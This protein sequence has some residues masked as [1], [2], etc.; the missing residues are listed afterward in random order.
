MEQIIR[1]STHKR[2]NI[3]DLVFVSHSDLWDHVILSSS[4][5]D[6]NPIIIK[7]AQRSF[8]ASI[9]SEYSNTSFNKNV[10]EYSF[11]SGATCGIQ[12]DNFFSY[13]KSNFNYALAH[14]LKRKRM[15]RRNMSFYYS[16]LTV[17]HVNKLQSARRG[18]ESSGCIAKL[19]KELNEFIELGKAALLSS[20]QY[21]TVNDAFKIIK[22][23]SGRASYTSKFFWKDCSAEKVDEKANLFKLFF[24]SVFKKTDNAKFH[25]CC[26]SSDIFLSN[27]VVETAKICW[28][29]KKIPPGSFATCDDVPPFVWRIC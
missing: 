2:G 25:H 20:F 10:F 7:Y 14:G 21:F 8:S 13:W 4:Y 9:S 3:L 19:E 28:K 12:V 6:H 16:S 29:V 5:S 22:Q 11:V 24:K 15:K 23:L 27:I 1:S 26:G 18:Y 17:H